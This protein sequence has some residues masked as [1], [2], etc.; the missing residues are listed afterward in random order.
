M[1]TAHPTESETIAAATTAGLFLSRD[2]GEAFGRR[3]GAVKLAFVF[4][5]VTRPFHQPAFGLLCR[6]QRDLLLRILPSG[7]VVGYDCDGVQ[8]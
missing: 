8:S 6:R 7:A 1:L 5:R 2:G 3:E 4:Q